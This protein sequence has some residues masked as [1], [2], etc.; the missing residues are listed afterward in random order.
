MA[1]ILAVDDEPL[2]CRLLEISLSRLGHEVLTTTSGLAG[3]EL[4]Q[5]VR[6]SLVILD[7]VLPDTD[8]LEMLQRIREIAPQTAVVIFTAWGSELIERK[9]SSLGARAFLQKGRV[10]GLLR[11]TV[12]QILETQ[13]VVASNKANE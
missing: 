9:A 5:Q 1:T 3:I 13:A 4:V 12:S 6:P 7:L 11:S 2:T 10:P 8:G